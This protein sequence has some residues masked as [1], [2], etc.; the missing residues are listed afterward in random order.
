MKVIN[1]IELTCQNGSSNK[2]YRV[3]F[4]L[5]EL[6]LT[7]ST[8]YG[9]IG[10]NGSTG[11]GTKT[12]IDNIRLAY[13]DGNFESL[14]ALMAREA[15]ALIKSKLKKGYQGQPAEHIDARNVINTLYSAY[16]QIFGATQAQPVQAA[17]LTSSA[18]KVEI[19]SVLGNLIVC[20]KVDQNY[21][22]ENIGQVSNPRNLK[23]K[24]GDDVV[25][26]VS[27]N[28]LWEIIKAA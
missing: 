12:K 2:F 3:S 15:N 25:I 1:C 19:I 21:T 16:P 26:D 10:K 7:V 18:C 13:S 9:P 14:I 22:Y 28:G 8:Q 20:A 6:Q 24:T 4:L 5:D 11:K 27:K 17:E 23:V